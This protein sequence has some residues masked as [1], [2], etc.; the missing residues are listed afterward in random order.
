MGT[1]DMSAMDMDDMDHGAMDMAVCPAHRRR[2][3][4]ADGLH[5]QQ[6]ASSAEASQ[7]LVVLLSSP[8]SL[9]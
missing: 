9:P 3:L 1:M 4:A 5:V 8:C 2:F 7:G 6:I